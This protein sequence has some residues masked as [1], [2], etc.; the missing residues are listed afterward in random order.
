MTT[1][2]C[3]KRLTRLQYLFICLYLK[4][5]RMTV[6]RRIIRKKKKNEAS[7]ALAKVSGVEELERATIILKELAQ[8]NQ[9]KED[10][11]DKKQTLEK[12]KKEK[13]K[14]RKVQHN[15]ENEK[16]NRLKEL[17]NLRKSGILTD[18]EFEKLKSN[19]IN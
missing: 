17:D 13:T 18:Q 6:K 5:I 19:L 9:R 16:I 2:G 14:T 11:K 1:D 3:F 7:E 15:I 4:K 10:I 8:R 12:I